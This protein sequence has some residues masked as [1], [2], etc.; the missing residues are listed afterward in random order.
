LLASTP[1]ANFGRPFRLDFPNG[2]WQSWKNGNRLNH[3]PQGFAGVQNAIHFPINDMQNA[4]D[5]QMV[6]CHEVTKILVTPV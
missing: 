6:V 4:E 3:L 2:C 5:L 1:A